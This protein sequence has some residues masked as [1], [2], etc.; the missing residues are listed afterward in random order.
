MDFKKDYINYVLHTVIQNEFYGARDDIRIRKILEKIILIPDVAKATFLA[1]KTAGLEILFKYLLYISDKIDKSQLTVFNLKDNF[2]YDLQNL[3]KICEGIKKFRSEIQKPAAEEKEHEIEN[4]VNSGRAIVEDNREQNKIVE[5]NHLEDNLSEWNPTEDTLSE[6]ESEETE[7]EQGFTLIENKRSESTDDEVFGLEGITR[8]IEMEEEAGNISATNEQE[9]AAPETNEEISD[10]EEEFIKENE[11]AVQPEIE[12]AETDIEAGDDDILTAADVEKINCIKEKGE[13]EKREREK[14]EREKRE[15]EKEELEI[16]IKN[17]AKLEDEQ[18]DEMKEG[19]VKSDVYYRFENKFFEEVK[20]LEKLFSNAE[21]ECRAKQYVKLYAA[22]YDKPQAKLSEKSLQ[23]FSEIIEISSEL[24]S[25]TRQLSFDLTAEIFLTINLL[26]TKAINNPSLINPER[27]KLLSSSLLLV[28]SLIKGEDYLGYDELV[29]KIESLKEEL[30]KPVE[31]PKKEIIEE[32]PG[33]EEFVKVK[34]VVEKSKTPIVSP[35]PVK[36]TKVEPETTEPEITEP[37]ITEQEAEPETLEPE[38]YKPA[39]VSTNKT[40]PIDYPK[41]II[42][43]HTV[44]TG[45]SESQNM[46]T[47]LFK[48]KYL[49]KEFEKNFTNVSRSDGEYSKFEILDEI[50]NLNNLLRMLAKISAS[51]KNS[52][53][54]KLSE[55]S[56]VFLKYLKDYRMN[57][58]DA[59]IQQ[60]IKYIIFTFKMLL[61]DRKPEDFDVL[62]QYL[63]NPVKIFTDT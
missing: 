20:I 6:E 42:K 10:T 48:M 7:E 26:F 31:P 47:V 18:T 51:V 22:P 39:E 44:N 27:T 2:E 36:K 61:T 56:Y 63:N 24:A 5:E 16:E 50:D 46:E 52:D 59:E 49:V 1:G 34:P 38:V 29:K 41:E 35:E 17:S 21:K 62:V 37:E 45:E 8:S 30:K 28:T 43:R 60:I 32:K 33:L 14:G 4:D 40:K 54:L 53:V 23:C 13:R 9:T 3:K 57:L 11:F 25:L 19:S 58:L 12:I 55:V 15:R